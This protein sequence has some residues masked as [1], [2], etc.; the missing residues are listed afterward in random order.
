MWIEKQQSNP[1]FVSC[2]V[3]RQIDMDTEAKSDES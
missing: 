2:P 1:Y 3:L